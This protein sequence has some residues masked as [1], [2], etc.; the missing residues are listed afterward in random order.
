VDDL[1][2]GGF[3][4]TEAC[5]LAAQPPDLAPEIVGIAAARHGPAL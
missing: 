3:G 5:D 4:R 2:V 1:A